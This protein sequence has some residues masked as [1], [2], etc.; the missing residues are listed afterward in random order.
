[1]FTFCTLIKFFWHRPQMI[2]GDF[3]IKDNVFYWNFKKTRH[4]SLWVEEKP[5]LY[6]KN[7]IFGGFLK[8]YLLKL[9]L[10]LLG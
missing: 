6:G 9:T 2:M 7:S 5:H 4:P 10:F 8:I 1:M 3:S